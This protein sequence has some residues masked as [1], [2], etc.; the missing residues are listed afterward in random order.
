[1]WNTWEILESVSNEDGA[2][3]MEHP[4]DPG[5]DPYPSVWATS[6]YKDFARAAEMS[7]VSFPQGALGQISRKPTTIA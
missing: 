1:M 2:A 6:E 5:T 3:A 4:E 7:E